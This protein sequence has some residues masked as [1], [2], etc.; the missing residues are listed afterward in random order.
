MYREKIREY[1]DH[2][3]RSYRK[4]ADYIMSNYYDVAFMT[5]AQ[6]AY[7]VGVDTTTVVRFSQRLGYNGY[8]D[9]LHDVREQVKSEIYA[10]YEPKPL[11]PN[12]PA[13]V[14]N[15]RIEQERQ[16]LQQ[17]LV[18]N[19]PV[20]LEA[21]ARLIESIE[22]VVVVGEGYAE[23]V[24]EMVAQQFRHRGI[25]A[26]Y[27]PN[28]AVKKAATLM[29]LDSN[30]LV[31]GI[32]ATAYGRDVARAMEFARARGAKTLGIIG[33]LA[34]PVNRISDLVIYA[35]TEAIGPLPSI[36][37]LD[38]ALSGLVLIAA[39]ESEA[40]VDRHLDAF[41]AAYQFLTQED[42]ITAMEA[43]RVPEEA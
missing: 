10:A 1:Y 20:H 18:Q 7:A 11:A 37:A 6:L 41:E 24:A 33:S 3:S 27:L 43:A 17:M 25:R 15:D 22:R 29:T 14:F 13:G 42:V 34:S 39:K 36:V 28:D 32:S 4:V 2:L 5:A 30:V 16:N 35:P 21:V 8:P 31:I 23:A 38:A 19:P 26:D 9:L 40:T 12:N